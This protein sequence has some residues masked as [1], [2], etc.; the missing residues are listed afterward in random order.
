MKWSEWIA[1]ANYYSQ[2]EQTEA[3]LVMQWSTA[4]ALTRS[5]CQINPTMRAVTIFAVFQLFENVEEV[6]FEKYRIVTT[7]KSTVCDRALVHDHKDT[8]A[9]RAR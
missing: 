5:C 4:E 2:L 8:K 7:K 9:F 1:A 3:S 6:Q